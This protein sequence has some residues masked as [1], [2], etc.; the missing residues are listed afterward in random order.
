MSEQ[1]HEIVAPSSDDII[2]SSCASGTLPMFMTVTSSMCGLWHGSCHGVPWRRE[3]L[4]SS[5]GVSVPHA[6]GGSLFSYSS[7]SNSVDL[8]KVQGG[9]PPPLTLP[10]VRLSNMPMSPTPIPRPVPWH[11]ALVRCASCSILLPHPPRSHVPLHATQLPAC[12][13]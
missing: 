4:H 3:K 12:T 7:F 11:W 10:H 13:P 2:L 5:L 1:F 6:R 8:S 9:E